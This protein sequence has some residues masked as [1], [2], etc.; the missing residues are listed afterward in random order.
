MKIY[1]YNIASTLFLVV[2]LF[3]FFTEVSWSQSFDS[4]KPEVIFNKKYSQV[5]SSSND[6]NNALFYGQWD[7]VE[8]NIFK[9]EDVV[10][11]Y[12]RFECIKKRIIISK[13]SYASPFIFETELDYSSGSNRGG[14]VIRANPIS[15]EHV[16]EPAQG[17]PGFNS[18]GISF[19]PGADGNSMI[20]QFTGTF[21][22][23]NTPVTRISIPKP[24]GIANMMGRG[25][26][27]VEDFMHTIY[28]YYNS[29]PF[30]RIDFGNKTGNLYS[31]GTVYNAK[32]QV[33]GTFSNM[34]VEAAGKISIAQRDATL[35]LYGVTIQYNDL[36][37]QT[38][39]FEI[40]AG[41]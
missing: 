20:V 19:Y 32:M 33:A 23:N 35:R 41:N 38:I 9:A 17:D 31:S 8:S 2:S 25:T 13:Q 21:N 15:V 4:D 6:W 11:N 26:L 27:R 24:E 40:Q 22:S 37:K 1:I 7:A 39:S 30:I 34:E 14:V 28:V 29:F 36:E 10:S 3:L 5:F 18:E 12:L 16:Q